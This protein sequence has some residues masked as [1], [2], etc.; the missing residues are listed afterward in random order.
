[1]KTLSL[2]S[3]KI[4]LEDNACAKVYASFVGFK[5]SKNFN[6]TS[7]DIILKSNANLEFTQ[8]FD[9]HQ[10]SLYANYIRV[11]QKKA[12]YF[13]SCQIT[14]K[15]AL[16]RNSMIVNLEEEQANC[17]LHGIYLIK[18]KSFAD[19]FLDIRHK[20]K[21]T[22]SNQLFKGILDDYSKVV[23]NGKVVVSKYATG[24]DSKQLNKSLLLS[25]D[26]KVYS[27]PQLDI[28]HHEVKCAHG[29]TIGQL[30]PEQL[31]Y[32]KSRGIDEH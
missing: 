24:V 21:N 29:A 5:N 18:D 4:I 13:K 32:F 15:N 16:L 10:S 11:I 17:D 31:F 1:M 26:A 28:N 20:T 19:F 2:A 25:N 3:N 14:L 8:N 30:N 27:R 22:Y 9:D 7:L 23:F 6:S 12:S